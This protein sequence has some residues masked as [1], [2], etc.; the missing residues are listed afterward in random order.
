MPDTMKK[1]ASPKAEA[2]RMAALANANKV[3]VAKKLAKK[4][5]RNGELTLA[6]ALLRMPVIVR[7]MRM[8]ECLLAAPGIGPQ[9]VR[10]ILARAEVSAS[11][12]VRT[13]DRRSRETVLNEIAR[14]CPEIWRKN[15]HG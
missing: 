3:R 9:K 14:T 2:Q 6:E 4:K 13:C 11:A 1:S 5:L 7:E 15:L 12:K 8:E 10:K